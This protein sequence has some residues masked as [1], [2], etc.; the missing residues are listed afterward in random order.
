M[1]CHRA[2]NETGDCIWKNTERRDRQPTWFSGKCGLRFSR[3]KEW[4]AGIQ[5]L[6][7]GRKDGRGWSVRSTGNY[8]QWGRRAAALLLFTREEPGALALEG[9]RE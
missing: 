7:S 2:G 9:R 4:E 6:S 8:G 3:D 1:S 5:G